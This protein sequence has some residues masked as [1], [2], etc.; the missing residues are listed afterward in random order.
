MNEQRN[1]AWRDELRK[2]LKA[3]ERSDIPR[4]HMPEL[5]PEY[6][7]S[8]LKEEVNTGLT[9][10]QAMLEA[11]RC[12][13]CANPTCVTGCPVEINIPTFIKYIEKGDFLN[14]AATLKETSALPA[15]CGRVCTQEKQCES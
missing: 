12:L 14:A 1:E 7:N 9:V 10:E 4:V 3:K 6:R 8:R 2:S 13:D 15:V 5:K 11:K